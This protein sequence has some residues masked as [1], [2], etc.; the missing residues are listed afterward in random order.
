[1]KWAIPPRAIPIHSPPCKESAAKALALSLC[2]SSLAAVTRVLDGSHGSNLKLLT[3][4]GL[5]NYG[6]TRVREVTTVRNFLGAYVQIRD[7]YAVL[8]RF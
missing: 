4:L 2:P 7:G 8:K 5:K 3:I 6:I 1:M